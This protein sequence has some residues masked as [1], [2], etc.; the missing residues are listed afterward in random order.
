MPVDPRRAD[1][2]VRG[3]VPTWS[4]RDAENEMGRNRVHEWACAIANT[5]ASRRRVGGKRR[6]S[7]EGVCACVRE[8]GCA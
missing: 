3:N 5:N 7:E 8:T 1:K 4:Q 6:A 2:R